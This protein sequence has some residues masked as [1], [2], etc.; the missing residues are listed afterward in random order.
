MIERE[1]KT[2][3]QRGLPP[4]VR[5]DKFVTGDF[6]VVEHMRTKDFAVG[7]TGTSFYAINAQRPTCGIRIFPA[8]DT[9]CG[10]SSGNTEKYRRW[11]VVHPNDSIV[12]QG[13]QSPPSTRW[14]VVWIG[15]VVNEEGTHLVEPIIFIAPFIPVSAKKNKVAPF[16][17]ECGPQ[18]LT[19]VE[20]YISPRRERNTHVNGFLSRLFG[21]FLEQWKLMALIRWFPTPPVVED[22]ALPPTPAAAPVPATAAPQPPTTTPSPPPPPSSSSSA[23]GRRPPTFGRSS[24]G[25]GYG[26]RAKS[27]L[28]KAQL[29]LLDQ[30]DDWKL[31]AEKA[32]ASL[33]TLRDKIARDKKRARA[34]KTP[35]PQQRE[36]LPSKPGR[37]YLE[38]HLEEF[39]SSSRRLKW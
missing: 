39:Y 18:D 37:K 11:Q 5:I 3:K 36:K 4:I 10:H 31:R 27:P 19:A 6:S 32:E 29:E 17:L 38:D 25:A 26:L 7:G 23:A 12:P 22:T 15:V 1:E 21:I 20:G 28:T 8:L 24:T 33:A 13:F 35:K 16:I 2:A 34:R 9:F 30:A 14:I